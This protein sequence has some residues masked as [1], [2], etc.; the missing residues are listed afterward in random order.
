[1]KLNVEDIEFEA[2]V[3]TTDVCGAVTKEMMSP[4]S[5]LRDSR[6]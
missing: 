1:M 3:G 2:L 6:G 4:A 5:S